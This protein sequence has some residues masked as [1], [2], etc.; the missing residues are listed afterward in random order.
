MAKYHVSEISGHAALGVPLVNDSPAPGVLAAREVVAFVI[1]EH[2]IMQIGVG[3]QDE[4][5]SVAALIHG[6]FQSAVI[7]D[8]STL[9]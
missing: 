6:F 7:R 9:I 2:G 3:Q 1:P 8:S 5:V 4:V